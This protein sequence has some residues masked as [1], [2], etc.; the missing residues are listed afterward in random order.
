[1]PVTITF[2]LF[3]S[4][5][6]FLPSPAVRNQVQLQ[7]TETTTINEL[8]DQYRV[9]RDLAH[10]VLVNGIFIQPAPIRHERDMSITH[11]DFFRLLARLVGAKAIQCCENSVRINTET[12]H[13]NI[14]LGPERRRKIALLELP[15]TTVSLEFHGYDQAAYQDFMRQFTLCFHKG[16]G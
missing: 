14:R 15:A 11:A 5:A 10:L 2:K 4:L 8:I 3:A 13:I 6:E 7:I 16:G 9:P 12:G 1:V